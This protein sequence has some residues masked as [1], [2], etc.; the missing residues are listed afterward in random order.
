MLCKAYNLVAK[1]VS[2]AD[3]IISV[4]QLGEDGRGRQLTSVLCP[5]G[6]EDGENVEVTL[7][8]EKANG[9]V[10]KPRISKVEEGSFDS[11]SQFWCARISTHGAYVRG[12][13]GNVSHDITDPYC[14]PKLVAKGYGAFGD[15]GRTGTWDDIIVVV[16]DGSILRVKPSRGDAYF[17]QFGESCVHKIN[18][19]DELDLL[20]EKFDLENRTRI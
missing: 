6:I 19:V 13:N 20:G 1:E 4:I 18:S 2:V 14:V 10:T 16:R 12:A 15:A 5:T 9:L 8:E 11:S 7:G 17:L 3:R